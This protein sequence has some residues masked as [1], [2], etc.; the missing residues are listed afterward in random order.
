MTITSITSVNNNPSFKAN[1]VSYRVKHWN[2]ICKEDKQ[3]LLSSVGISGIV[4]CG[5]GL[6]SACLKKGVKSSLITGVKAGLAT[7]CF[8]V[9]PILNI[10]RPKIYESD[11][12]SSGLIM[13]KKGSN[14]TLKRMASACAKVSAAAGVGAGLITS[15]FTKR[16]KLPWIVGGI[17]ALAVLIFPDPF[18][19]GK[20]VMNLSDKKTKAGQTKLYSLEELQSLQ[21]KK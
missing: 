19:V 20:T 2:N 8:T 12:S 5:V 11:I 1:P 14:Y 6:L 21:T 16:K 17:S 9:V 3:A 15:C 10:P 13:M 4:G 18:I 7:L